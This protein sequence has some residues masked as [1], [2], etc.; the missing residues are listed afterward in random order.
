MTRLALIGPTT[1]LGKEIRVLLDRRR[2]IWS[3]LSLYSVYEDEIGVLTEVRGEAAIVE[4]LED[5]SLDSADLTIACCPMVECNSF[6]KNL[7]AGAA[8]LMTSADAVLHDGCPVVARINL[9]LAEGSTRVLSPHPGAILVSTLL[10]PLRELGLVE[11]I[12]TLIEPISMHERAAL[13][14][15]IEETRSLLNFQPRAASSSFP[16]QIAFNLLPSGTSSSA[17]A[18]LV[19]ATLEMPDLG[20]ALQAIQGSVFHAITASLFVRF[21]DPVEIESLKKALGSHPGID[22]APDPELLGPVDAP[23]RDEV[24]VGEIQES[25]DGF[26]IWAVMDNLTIGGADN[27]LR[28]A[29]RMLESGPAS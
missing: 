15:V 2:E 25:N 19:R 16:A 18:D 22:F 24:L 14:E 21:R 3:K 12:G 17:L 20:L 29:E 26:W 7:R 9:G 13:D 23:N 8:V 5:D 4:K 27:A 28:I 6:L 11:S 1:L 10:A